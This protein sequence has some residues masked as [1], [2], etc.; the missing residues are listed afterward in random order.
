MDV[1]IQVE[2]TVTVSTS[3]VKAYLR[4]QVQFCR[5]SALGGVGVRSGMN[6]WGRLSGQRCQSM[7]VACTD[8]KNLLCVTGTG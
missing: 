6:S 7:V 5:S 8:K 2:G 3:T 1:T 4:T